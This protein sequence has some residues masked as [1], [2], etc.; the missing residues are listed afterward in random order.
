MPD[1]DVRIPAQDDTYTIRIAP[2]YIS[3]TDHNKPKIDSQKRSKPKPKKTP[4][5]P[6]RNKFTPKSRLSFK[7]TLNEIRPHKLPT[8]Y[9]VLN[10]LW[11]SNQPKD[12]KRTVSNLRRRMVA[13]FPKCWFFWRLMPEKQRGVP[14]LHLLG[15]LEDDM[16]MNELQVLITDWWAKLLGF[17]P[18]MVTDPVVAQAVTRTHDRLFKKISSEEPTTH[19]SKFHE[20]WM[21]LGKRWDVWN[22]KHIPLAVVEE[23]V[24][25]QQCHH[26]IKRVLLDAVETDIKEIEERFQG[27]LGSHDFAMLRASING[28]QRYLE[29]LR[30]MDDNFIFLTPE[31]IELVKETMRDFCE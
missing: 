22:Q 5:A 6:S 14:V 10:F 12:W 21:K 27:Q 20:S 30:A 7:K 11:T 25:K 24:I 28:K 8:Q 13:R 4:A 29:K 16:D 23:L 2:G 3:I 1:T 15:R 18:T 19:H 31:Y 17:D 9:I 26:E